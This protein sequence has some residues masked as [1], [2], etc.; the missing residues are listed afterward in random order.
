MVSLLPSSLKVREIFIHEEFSTNT[1]EQR[2]YPIGANGA[3]AP[4]YNLTKRHFTNT[5]HIQGKRDFHTF[6]TIPWVATTNASASLA[7]F[8]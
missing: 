2:K 3:S 1:A 4:Y 7:P 6:F 5:A 8:D